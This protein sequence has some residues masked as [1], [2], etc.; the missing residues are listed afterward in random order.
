MKCSAALLCALAAL[1]VPSSGLIYQL[2]E[3]EVDEF[4]FALR[5]AFGVMAGGYFEINLSLTPSM[6]PSFEGH[7]PPNLSIMLCTDTQ[8]LKLHLDAKNP[9]TCRRDAMVCKDVTEFKQGNKPVFHRRYEINEYGLYY[10]VVINCPNNT[11]DRMVP[12]N[13][14]GTFVVM[15]PRGE[16]LPAGWMPRPGMHVILTAMWTC[17]L[18]WWLWC[19]LPL[20]RTASRLH[21]TYAVFPLLKVVACLAA[22][23]YWRWL[24]ENGSVPASADVRLPMWA[25]QTAAEA[26]FFLVMMLTGCGW[27]VLRGALAPVSAYIAML[28]MCVASTNVVHLL[29]WNNL[30]QLMAWLSYVVTRVIVVVFVFVVVNK[31]I[32]EVHDREGIFTVMP[33]APG[34]PQYAATE[35]LH[36]LSSFKHVLVLW[37]V[38]NM[39]IYFAL[40]VFIKEWFWVTDLLYECLDLIFFL[41]TG[42]VYRVRLAVVYETYT[43]PGASAADAAEPLHAVHSES[44]QRRVAQLLQQQQQQQQQQQRRSSSSD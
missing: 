30:S 6:Y 14:N 24:S 33:Q 10:V 16:H 20:V 21:A 44:L 27:C 23:R 35:R 8:V 41:L 11:N 18:A 5:E 28:T 38:S 17:T 7:M 34:T 26:Y 22:A 36:I 42:I 15:N 12:F 2:R 1:A 4:S 9:A 43:P 37:V 25:A 3:V 19:W 32:A 13:Y 40:I 31:N 29:Q 39:L